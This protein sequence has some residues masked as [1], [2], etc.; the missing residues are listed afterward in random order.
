[1]KKRK[2]QITCLVAVLCVTVLLPSVIVPAKSVVNDLIFSNIQRIDQPGY[3]IITPAGYSSETQICSYGILSSVDSGI[4]RYQQVFALS[5]GKQ[6]SVMSDGDDWNNAGGNQQRNGLSTVQGPLTNDL[7]WSGGRSSLISW[8]P[9]TEGNRL[10]VVR[11]AGWPGAVHDSLVVAMDLSTGEELW[12]VEIPY[13]TNDWT[14]WV[15]GVKNGQVYA[16]RSGNGASVADN[17]YALDADSGDTL[18]VSTVLI[19]AGPYDGVVFASDGDPIIASFTDIWRFN[20]ND[21]SLVWHADR[22]G[23]VSGSCGGALFQNRFYVADAA[24]GGHILVAYDVET[25]ERLYQSPVMTGFTLQNTPFVGPDGTVYLSRTQNNPSTDYFYAFTDTGESLGEKWHRACAWTTFSEFAA[26]RDGSVYCVLPG[27]R[28]GKLDATT[29]DIIAQSD[30]LDASESYLSPHFAVDSR[31]TVFFSNGGFAEG[32]VSIFT[33]DLT[34][35]WNTTMVNINIGGPSL[36]NTG[37]LILCGT[38][39]NMRAYRS[40]QPTLEINITDVFPFI[41]GSITNVGEAVATNLSWQMT[42]T[43]GILGRIN[44]TRSDH[45]ATLDSLEGVNISLNRFIFGFG[46]ITILVSAI[47]DEGVTGEKTVE[48]SVFLVFVRRN[49]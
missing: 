43:G 14:T 30:I 33:P 24:P 5:P 47:C 7:L 49:T 2:M 25:G 21:G 6:A 18:W 15:G 34:A 41:S 9:V 13:H 12:S 36:G 3:S 32:K 26:G 40:S 37:V 22:L 29:G 11:Q 42:V 19:D 20:S 27:P 1:M 45:I 8:L 48:A 23:S 28:I 4:K 46:K 38:G 44:I 39:T 35:L 31:G 10:F 16:S 17:L